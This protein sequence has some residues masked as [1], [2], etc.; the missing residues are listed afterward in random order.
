MQDE[1][2]ES[3][4]DS[5]QCTNCLKQFPVD[6]IDLHEAYCCRNIRKCAHC[7]AMVDIKDM[8]EHIVNIFLCRPMSM[9]RNLAHIVPK[10]S[11]QTKS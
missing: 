10:S 5:Q 11:N 3:Q 4:S 1:Q 7:P 2:V 9:P 8:D 6:K